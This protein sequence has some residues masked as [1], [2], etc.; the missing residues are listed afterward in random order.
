MFGL[1]CD[2]IPQER[3]LAQND[4]SMTPFCKSSESSIRKLSPESNGSDASN[5]PTQGQQHTSISFET[6]L[7]NEILQDKVKSDG[8]ISKANSPV[9]E[10]KFSETPPKNTFELH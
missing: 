8:E 5:L 6:L 9:E 7:I 4:S 10:H 3:L 2:K 1:P